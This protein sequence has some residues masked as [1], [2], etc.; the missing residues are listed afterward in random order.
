LAYILQTK[1]KI[2]LTMQMSYSK[3]K[4]CTKIDF[5]SAPD[6]RPRWGAYS[7]PTDLLAGFKGSYF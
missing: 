4:M 5:I 2:A 1:I 6:G 7:A 3:A